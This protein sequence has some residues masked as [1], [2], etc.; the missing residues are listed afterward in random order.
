MTDQDSSTALAAYHSILNDR[1]HRSSSYY[2]CVIRQCSLK[3]IVRWQNIFVSSDLI[4]PTQGRINCSTHSYNKD[5]NLKRVIIFKTL[6][7]SNQINM[8]SLLHFSS[9]ILLNTKIV[10]DKNSDISSKHKTLKPFYLSVKFWRNSNL[11]IIYFSI[12][13]YMV[14]VGCSIIFCKMD[15]CLFFST[16]HARCIEKNLAWRSLNLQGDFTIVFQHTAIQKRQDCFT[17]HEWP[18]SQLVRIF[19]SRGSDLVRGIS[20][21]CIYQS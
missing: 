17:D 20:L 1:C 18:F 6:F 5:Q 2:I 21:L 15:A 9:E 7:R 11:P 3:Q 14:P 16:E 10:T 12:L 8:E 4:P 13:A 19:S